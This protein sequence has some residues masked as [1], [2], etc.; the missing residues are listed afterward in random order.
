MAHRNARLTV[1]GRRLLIQRVVAQG[2]PVAHVVEELGVSRA[3]GYKWLARW[4]A[5]GDAGRAD[6]SSAAHRLPAKTAPVCSSGPTQRSV[7]GNVRAASAMTNAS[8]AS[9]LPSPGYKSAM[10][11]IA[12]PGR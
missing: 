7:W 3:T 6:R 4:R 8:R 12:S 9:V 1:H 2:R 5:E 11:R 10:R